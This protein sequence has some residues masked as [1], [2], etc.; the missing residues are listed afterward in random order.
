MVKCLSVCHENAY[1]R[2][3][4]IWLFLMFIATF[5]LCSVVKTL[6]VSLVRQRDRPRDRQ[7]HLLS[8]SGQLKRQPLND[9]IKLKCSSRAPR[10]FSG[11][12]AVY[13]SK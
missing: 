1:F 10:Q 3:Q 12:K 11:V 6:I 2:I 4:K 8:C 5:P 9:K 13:Q 7:C